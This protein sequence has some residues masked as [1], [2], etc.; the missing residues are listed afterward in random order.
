MAD[1]EQMLQRGWQI[2]YKNSDAVLQT[3]LGPMRILWITQYIPRIF[4]LPVPHWWG[5]A[6]LMELSYKSSNT[7]IEDLY[8]PM[9]YEEQFLNKNI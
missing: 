1:S 8:I 3:D 7:F 4:F 5:R 2:A 6:G 9:I